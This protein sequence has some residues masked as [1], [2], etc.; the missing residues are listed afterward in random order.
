MIEY[1]EILDNINSEANELRE[2]FV[3]YF[4]DPEMTKTKDT[5]G[6]GVYMAKNYCLLS[7]MC[8]YLV[9]IVPGDKNRVGT[10]KP[11]RLLEWMS[12]QTRTLSESYDL[13]SHSYIAK[14]GG[15]LDVKIKRVKVLEGGSTYECE[16]FNIS[17]TLLHV[18]NKKVEDYQENGTLIAALET[19]NTVIVIPNDVI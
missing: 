11:L 15:P 16:K 14:R 7:R 2:A 6:C 8:R 12:F 3:A 19:F 13:P 4:N 10:K 1:G 9:V 17:V 5:T 18:N